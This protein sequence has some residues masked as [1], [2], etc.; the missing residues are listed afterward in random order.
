[1][2]TR[3]IQNIPHRIP[4]R[5]P[6]REKIGV[7]ISLRILL[8]ACTGIVLLPITGM[9]GLNAQSGGFAGSFSRMGF[10][11]RGMA[12]G[13]AMTAVDSQ[14][15]YGY[16]NP[17]LA[18]VVSESIQF[19]MASAALRFD[20]QI[21]MATAHFQ[22]PPSAGFSLSL[23]NARVSNIDGRTESGY[24]TE[25]FSTGE[26]QVIGNF[27]IRLSDNVLAGIGIK[28]NLANYHPEVPKSSS[29][30]FDAGFLIKP[31]RRLTLGLAVQDLL[32]FSRFDTSD[33]Y[34]ANTKTKKDYYPVR[35]K[36]GGAYK[37]TENWLMSM[38]YEIRLQTGVTQPDASPQ[39]GR[40]T[41]R[42]RSSFIRMGTAFE[43]HE[44]LTLRSGLQLPDIGNS[45]QLLP[46]AGFSLHL[47]FDRF[48]PSVDYAILSEPS[49]QSWMHVFA[50]QLRI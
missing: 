16:Y 49:Q 9:S 10:S 24:H 7:F 26:Y 28:Y 33:L 41:V 37:L 22:L 13:N 20:R 12:M 8:F 2:Q 38:D 48:S 36:A 31:V 42:S 29:A 30:G 47:P 15:S 18:A 40:E 23:L 6:P 44:R 5:T 21:H 50:I 3:R 25:T 35:L 4:G 39:S 17:A 19:D 32:A 46:G 34:T 11:P 27:G 14:G 1:M 45:N 43:I